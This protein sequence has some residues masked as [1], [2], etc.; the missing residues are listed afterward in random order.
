MKN[1]RE[2]TSEEMKTTEGG[3]V[4]FVGL[5]L[6]AVAFGYQYGKDAAERERK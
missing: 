4:G 1:Y 6:A 3:W 2:L 5:V